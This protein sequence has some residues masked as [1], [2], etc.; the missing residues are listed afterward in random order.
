[1]GK[2][3]EIVLTSEEMRELTRIADSPRSRPRE[4]FRARIALLSAKK[5]STT[6]TALEVG[7]SRQTVSLWR[8]RFARERMAGLKDRPGRGR[9]PAYGP[10]KVKEIV[11]ATLT[12]RPEGLTR[13]SAREMARVMGV[14]HM[15]VRRIWKAHGLKPHL[16]RPSKQSNDK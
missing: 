5:V 6:E 10:D 14:S 9:K 4:V 2:A 15:T 13:W 3:K 16:A 12:S 11:H 8:G 1:M 7:K